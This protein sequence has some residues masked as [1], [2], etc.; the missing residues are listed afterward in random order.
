MLYFLHYFR[1]N[2][3]M[4]FKPQYI[5]NVVV[6]FWTE[7]IFFDVFLSNYTNPAIK[8]KLVLTFFSTASR[9]RDSETISKQ[10]PEK[11]PVSLHVNIVISKFASTS[12]KIARVFF[13]L[14]SFF[15]VIVERLKTEKH[16]PLLDKIKYLVPTDLT[17][18]SLASIIRLVEKN[19]KKS[20][21]IIHWYCLFFIHIYS[22]K[23]LYLIMLKLL[24]YENIFC[25]SQLKKIVMKCLSFNMI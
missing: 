14:L 20:D 13:F 17:M 7:T 8:F 24:L 9:K 2:P 15:K 11:I 19:L 12:W 5:W 3:S 25:L 22:H 6:G 1:C 4:S 18:S 23:S 16:L 21:R 10:Y